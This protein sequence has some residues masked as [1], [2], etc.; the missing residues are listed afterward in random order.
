LE[1]RKLEKLLTMSANELSRLEIMQRVAEKRLKQKEAA[2]MLGITARQV[3][4]LVGKYRENGSGGLVSQRRGKA[5]NNQLAVD[6]KQKGL[7]L[8]KGKYH[9]FGPTLACEKLVEVEGLQISAESIR[10]IMISEGLWKARKERKVT[11]HQMRERRAC[12]GELVQIDGSPH[13]WFEERGATCTLLVAIDDATGKLVGLLFVEQESFHSYATLAKAYFE[14]YGRPVAFYSDKHGVFR[15]N[16]PGAGV[17]EAVTQFG[18]AMQ[19]LNIQILCANSP[20]AK[21]RVERANQTLQDRL[22][23]E[24]RLRDISTM[25]QGNAYLPDFIADFNQRFS[26]PARSQH[27]AHRPLTR[28]DNLA[29][30]LT[31]QEARIISKNLT[32]QFK[33]VVYQIQ[34]DRPSYALRNA[35]VT[36]CEDAAGL[37]TIVY[38]TKSL[39]FTVFHKQEHQAEIVD[40]KDVDRVLDNQRFAHTPAQDH[41]WRH[42]PIG[43]AI[44]TKGL[45]LRVA[46]EGCG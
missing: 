42:S 16:Q 37:I 2:E 31:W 30:I 21:G 33:K 40:T 3:R 28:L 38:K 36:V 11:V 25:E 23:K 5:S 13:G 35:Q 34:T 20:Q 7:D 6:V 46:Q 29:Q 8:L 1:D 15:V 17:A 27:D 39:K 12:F 24:M 4:R 45:P 32:I 22:V 18:R 44:D 14:R 43:K 19:E 9:G 41:P 26:V 10:Q